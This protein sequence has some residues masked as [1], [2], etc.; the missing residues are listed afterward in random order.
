MSYLS[1]LPL[2]PP[3]FTSKP[4]PETL[5]W[6]E[7]YMPQLQTKDLGFTF[8]SVLLSVESILYGLFLRSKATD[9]F[10]PLLPVP[11]MDFQ[12]SPEPFLFPLVL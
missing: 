7:H 9:I 2:S 4:G 11:L 5:P 6:F 10:F 1:N 12:C 8:Q 3:L